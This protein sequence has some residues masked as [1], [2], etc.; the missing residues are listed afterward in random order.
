MSFTFLRPF[1]FFF[2]ALFSATSWLFY[3]RYIVSSQRT[4]LQNFFHFEGNF[5]VFNHL[6]VDQPSSLQPGVLRRHRPPSVP[7]CVS[8]SHKTGRSR[9]RRREPRCRCWRRCDQF[10]PSG[11][12]RMKRRTPLLAEVASG[13][14]RCTRASVT[15][16]GESLFWKVK[17]SSCPDGP[18]H[19]TRGR[20]FSGG[21]TWPAIS[22]LRQLTTHRT[23]QI[24]GFAFSQFN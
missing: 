3:L 9:R 7:W 23:S 19:R 14:C 11:R 22:L 8:G 6:E 15:M 24:C 4:E 5:L 12:R 2:F 1:W 17:S 21:I 13:N 16:Q 10:H 18:R 20:M